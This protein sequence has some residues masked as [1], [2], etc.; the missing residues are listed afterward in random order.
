MLHFAAHQI[1]TFWMRTF[2]RMTCVKWKRNILRQ[3][4]HPPV[5]KFM[6]ETDTWTWNKYSLHSHLTLLSVSEDYLCFVSIQTILLCNN[7]N[8]NNNNNNT[9]V[10]RKVITVCAYLSRILEIVT[11]R[12]CIYFLYQLRRHTRHFVKV[13]LCLYLFLCVKHV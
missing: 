8:N 13:M 4:A 7:N 5:S 6:S 12:T 11:L 2:Y 3:S 9:Y 10:I 1:L